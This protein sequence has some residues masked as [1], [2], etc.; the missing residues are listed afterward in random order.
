M[1][2]KSKK[3]KKTAKE[4]KKETI[5]PHGKVFFSWE[6]KEFPSAGRSK[7]WYLGAGIIFFLLI[8]YALFSANFLFAIIIIMVVLILVMMRREANKIKFSITEDGIEI[9]QNFYEY[10][11]IK[12]FW[13]IYEPPEIKTLYFEPKSFFQPKIPVPLENQNPIKIREVLLQYLTEDLDK[14]NEPVSDQLSRWL[15]L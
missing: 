15:K 2:K 11:N 9:G 6:F 5:G 3:R 7:S 4:I 14:E 13:I 12:N 8:I 1:P 10:K